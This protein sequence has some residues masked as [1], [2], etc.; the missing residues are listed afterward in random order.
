VLPRTPGAQVK[1]RFNTPGKINAVMD[2]SH[3]GALRHRNRQYSLLHLPQEAKPGRE[4]DAE[5]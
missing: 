4:E 2:N 1:Q 5:N 3:R